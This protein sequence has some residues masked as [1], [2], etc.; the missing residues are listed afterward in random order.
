MGQLRCRNCHW[1]FSADRTEC[2]A[3][4]GRDLGGPAPQFQQFQGHDT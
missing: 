4:R 2:P 3:C 1:V